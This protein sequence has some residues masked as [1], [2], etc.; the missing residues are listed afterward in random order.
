MDYLVEKVRQSNTFPVLALAKFNFQP[1]AD[2]FLDGL[3]D[4]SCVFFKVFFFSYYLSQMSQFERNNISADQLLSALLNSS[5]P[6]AQISFAGDLVV[7][8]KAMRMASENMS[9]EQKLSSIKVKKGSKDL[10]V[11]DSKFHS[12][13]KYV[14]L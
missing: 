2:F 12:T 3:A 13:G 1:C 4:F 10:V 7:A 6:G 8:I 9:P 5:A 14:I 11:V